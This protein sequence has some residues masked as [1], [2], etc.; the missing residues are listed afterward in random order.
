MRTVI[1][2][3]SYPQVAWIVLRS[4]AH[5]GRNWLLQIDNYLGRG[6]DNDI[7]LDDDTVSDRHARIKKEGKAF[8]LYDLGATNGTRLNGVRIQREL[9]CHNDVIQ[10]GNVELVFVQIEPV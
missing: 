4:G 3:K 5:S 7:I 2:E 1:A 10:M 6:V 8:V 9:L